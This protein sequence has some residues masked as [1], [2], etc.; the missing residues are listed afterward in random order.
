MCAACSCCRVRL[1][2]QF[3]RLRG[4][5][6]DSRAAQPFLHLGDPVFA[7]RGMVQAVAD[8]EVTAVEGG[9][10]LQ[11]C[12]VCLC[13]PACGEV[14]KHPDVE[15]A[16]R[17]YEGDLVTGDRKV[18]AQRKISLLGLEAAQNQRFIRASCCVLEIPCATPVPA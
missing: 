1:D 17:R 14:F 4:Q 8:Q 18:V 5:H 15:H 6:I 3:R 12:E 13:Y 16:P 7:I 11:L 2:A 9:D 10:R